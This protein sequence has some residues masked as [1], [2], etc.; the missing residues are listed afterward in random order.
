MTTFDNGGNPTAYKYCAR[1]FEEPSLLADPECYRDDKA[2]V[3]LHGAAHALTGA[4]DV[5]QG[6][7]NIATHSYEDN[8]RSA[9]THAFFAK[10]KFFSKPKIK[11]MVY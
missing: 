2:L 1:F 10:G 5:F 11:L 3:I 6:Y 4:A 9:D 8:M 7:N